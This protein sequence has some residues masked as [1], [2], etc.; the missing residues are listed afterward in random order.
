M[1]NAI[2]AALGLTLLSASVHAQPACLQ[3]G[4]IWSWKPLDKKTLIVED[5]LHRKFKVSIMG[6]CPALPYKLTLGFKSNGGINGLDCLRRGDDVIS[7]DVGIPYICPITS[8]VPYT[9]AMER[10]DQTAAAAGNK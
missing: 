9:P 7:H 1:R 5:L 4:R 6:F 8:I 3:V 10:A 2:F